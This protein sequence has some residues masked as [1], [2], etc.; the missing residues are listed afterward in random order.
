MLIILAIIGGIVA[1][2]TASYTLQQIGKDKY[3]YS[4]FSIGGMGVSFI[5][6]VA[7]VFAYSYY[8]HDLI[9]N[10]VVALI[11]GVLPYVG[12]FIRDAKRTSITLAITALMLRFIIS[13]LFIMIIIWYFFMRS[14]SD[15][16]LKTVR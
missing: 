10:M 6:A 11:F 12:M 16:R 1:I 3:H 7:L 8:K 13:A 4:I 2:L 9:L 15:D 14:S 5:G